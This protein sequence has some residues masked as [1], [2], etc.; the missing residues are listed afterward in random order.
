VEREINPLYY[1]EKGLPLNLA[2]LIVL[3]LYAGHI[4]CMKLKWRVP[5]L[6]MLLCV[7]GSR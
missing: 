7:K 4:I 5:N 6:G 1:D 2:R 3:I